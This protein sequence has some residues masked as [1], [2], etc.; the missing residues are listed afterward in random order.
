MTH[1]N[2]ANGAEQRAKTQRGFFGVPAVVIVPVRINDDQGNAAGKFPRHTRDLGG[3]L[4]GDD[5]VNGATQSEIVGKSAI[6][7]MDVVPMPVRVRAR[8]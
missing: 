1:R 3:L 7:Q 4:A 5:P 6:H 8:L 2:L